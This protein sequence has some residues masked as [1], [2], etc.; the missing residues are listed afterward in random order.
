MTEADT[1]SAAP[2]DPSP[3]PDGISLADRLEH[4]FAEHVQGSA[5]AVRTE[6]YNRAHQAKEALRRI[7]A[8]IEEKI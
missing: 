3:A 7:L 1:G 5:V 6:L 2:P 8:E 4:W